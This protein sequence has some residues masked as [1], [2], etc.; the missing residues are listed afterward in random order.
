MESHHLSPKSPTARSHR[1]VFVTESLG[2][3]G[4]ETHLA[5][6]LPDLKSAG[7]DV[8]VF[9]F[10]EK[11]ERAG[12][13]ENEGIEVIAAPSFGARKRSFLA[14]FR[15]AAGQA[16]LLSLI[17]RWR[18]DIVHFFLPGPYL[19]GAPVAI[20][21]RV[22]V[23]IMSR[24]SMAD[25]R[26]NW[27]FIAPLEHRLH[28]HM[29]AVI[30]NS[31]AITEELRQEGVPEH[32][33]HL[34]YNGVRQSAETTS[35]SDARQ[36]L[37]IEPHALVLSTIANL[38][39][40]KGH[41]DLIA[42]LTQIGNRLPQPWLLLGAGRDGGSLAEISHAIEAS[43]LKGNVRLLGEHRDVPQLLAASD[44]GVLAPIRNEGFSNAI[45][46]SMAAGLPMVVTDVGGNDEA[47]SD[48][49]TGIVVRAADPGALGAAILRLANDTELRQSMGASAKA[50][51]AE[52][53]SLEESTARYL[54]L[55]EDL[56]ANK[57][58][59]GT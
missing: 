46:E 30:G 57:A 43:G 39:P 49:K 24:R 13:F 38:M 42:A 9:C 45:L 32:K 34:I 52:E 53:F 20:A 22:P 51:V 47:V 27:P 56:L 14:F 17:R 6:L 15:I 37:D 4:T 7:F 36:Q 18:P 29:D 10:T 21:T 58:P 23:K 35:R 1:I 41:V 25:Y 12:L 8:G 40:Y 31:N 16:K 11:G 26:A 48:G 54:T 5:L 50:R 33:L 59:R 2:I 44:I 55:Y 3:G 28:R 19:A